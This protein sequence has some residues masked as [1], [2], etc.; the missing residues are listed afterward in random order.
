MAKP[1]AALWTSQAASNVA[2]GVLA[3]AAPLAL[4]ALTRDPVVV[5]G[6]TVVQFLPWLL[7]TL[8]S[9]ALVDRVDRRRVLVGGNLLRTAGF[10]LLA[11][12]LASGAQ[13]FWLLYGAVFIAGAAETLV[14]NAALTIPPRIVQRAQLERANGRLFA[15]QSVANTFVGPPA[16]AFLVAIGAALAFGTG[17]ALFALAAGAALLLPHLRPSG[18]VQAEPARPMVADIRDG[19]SQFWRH[20]LLRRVAL[21]SAAINFFGTATGAV[22]VLLATGPLHVPEAAYGLFLAVPAAGAILGSL[23]A[24][25]VIPAVGGGPVTWAAA[26]LPAASYAVLG[27]GLGVVAGLIAMFIA[28]VATACNQVVVSTLRQAAVPDAML[29]RV[30]AAYRL[31]VLGVVPFGALAGGALASVAGLEA[32]FVIAAAGLALA[33]CVLAP[34]VTTAALRDAELTAAAAA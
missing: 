16:G 24:E 9:G 13:S 3:A 4:A 23:I 2:D 1:F 5:A 26:L 18:S 7:F 28:A 8:P 15:T 19:W 17:S 12:A 32:M 20:A 6:M 25:R 34:R 27:L 10:A 30:T 21:I 31:I 33:A 22:L 11:G 14:D 29:G